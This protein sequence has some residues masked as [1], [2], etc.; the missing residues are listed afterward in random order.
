MAV[1]LVLSFGLFVFDGVEEGGVVVGPDEGADA[2][3]GVGER[4]AAAQ[5]FDVQ[6][7]LAET[8]VVD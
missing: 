1:E 2:L 8:G 7:V 6:R 3:G 5:I 4:F